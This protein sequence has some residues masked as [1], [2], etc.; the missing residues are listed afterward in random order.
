M[1]SLV[2][3]SVHTAAPRRA[4][5]GAVPRRR[6]P[7]NWPGCSPRPAAALRSSPFSSCSAGPPNGSQPGGRRLGRRAARRRRRP[8]RRRGALPA[9]RPGLPD[10]ARR[11]LPARWPDHQAD[12]SRG[13]P[14][15]AGAAAG[16]TAVGRRLRVGQHR[17]R[18]V[19]RRHR[20]P[21]RHS[22][23]AHS[24]ASESRPT[25]APSASR[26][27]SAVRRPRTST[28]RHPG[29]DIH[30]RR[31]DQPGLVSACIDRLGPG[32]RLVANAVTAESGS[33]AGGMAHPARR[34]TAPLPAL[35]RWNRSAGSPA[36]GRRCRSPS[37]R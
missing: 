32:G 4:G 2:T 1:I 36:G 9:R 24:V 26:W 35:P 22:R 12:R 37:G 5:R 28:A 21:R 34:R 19:P 33:P 23:P 31:A 25:A 13:H 15:G 27:T 16:A 17:C 14:R 11:R 20:L 18:M 10:P 3:A 30:R 8:Q 7:P 6:H 29:C